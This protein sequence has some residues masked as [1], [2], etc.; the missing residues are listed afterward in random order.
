MTVRHALEDTKN[1]LNNAG[2]EPYEFEA[3][4]LVAAAL[5]T[6][7]GKLPLIMREELSAEV[8]DR[9][10]KTVNRRC[11]GEP[12]Q[13]ILGC[14]EFYSLPFFVGE[15]VLIPRADTELLV[16]CALELINGRKLSVADLCSGS[17]C[18]AVAVA[19]NAPNCKVGAYELSEKALAYINKNAKLNNVQIN[20]VECDITRYF[21]E[22]KFDLILSNPP[23]I[24]SKVVPALSKEVGFEPVMALDG[25]NDGLDFYRAITRRWTSCLKPGGALMV[26]IGI[27]QQDA[28]CE[29]MR[30]AGLTD[31][32]IKKDINKIGRVI[33]G[34]VPSPT[35]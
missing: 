22:E 10:D 17:G 12:L 5:S 29:L 35:P 11:V 28:V 7:T 30:D 23:Y 33:I 4:Q 24:E 6:S 26:E 18:I 13:Y 34:T 2:I 21:C 32:Q 20:I 15:G 27:G 25:G 31:I 3:R 14:W 9:L 1:K 19:K 8:K 16:D